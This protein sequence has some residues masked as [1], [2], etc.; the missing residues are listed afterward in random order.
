MAEMRDG[1]RS[2]FSDAYNRLKDI[3]GTRRLELLT[4]T[5][6]THFVDRIVDRECWLVP[7]PPLP[8]MQQDAAFDRR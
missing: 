7:P 1:D 4:S 5:V 6:S 2:V 3:V 8:F